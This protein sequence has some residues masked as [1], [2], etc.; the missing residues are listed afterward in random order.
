MNSKVQFAKI[1]DVKSPNRA[2]Y[3]D[4]GTDWFVPNYSEEFIK[5]V[6]EKNKKNQIEYAMV[7]DDNGERMCKFIV[8]PGSQINI[9]SG[10]RV[11]ILDKT[12]YLEAQNKSGVASKYGLLVGACVVDADYQGEVHLN[13]LNVSNKPQEILTG[14]KLVQFIHKQ[15]INTY[16]EEISEDAYNNIEISERGEGG[17]SSTGEK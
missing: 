12:T 16:W 13:M 3:T 7:F 6:Q 11:N 5:A 2:H 15:F 1:R 4:A 10:I 8:Y 17:F 9:P 14:Q